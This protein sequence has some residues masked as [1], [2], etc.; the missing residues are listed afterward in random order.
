MLQRSLARRARRAASFLLFAGLA[1]VGAPFNIVVNFIGGLSPTQQAVFTTAANTWTALLPEYQPGINIPSLTISAQGTAIDGVGNVLGSAGPDLLNVTNQGGFWLATTG[2]MQFDTADLAN[3]EANNT[4][5]PVV[6]HE[7]AHVMGFG[8]LWRLNN[9]YAPVLNPGQFTGANAI[10]AYQT[11]FNQP[12]SLFVPVELG[13]GPGTADGHWDEVDFGAGPT[14]IISAQGD[15]QFEL[16]T[17]WL[18]TPYFISNTTIASFVDIGFQSAPVAVPEPG[19]IALFGA[20]LL[21]VA[22]SRRRS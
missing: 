5:L 12:G 21:F 6:L 2:S 4:L 13:G 3:L 10:A 9:V 22:L 17:G 19:T 16:M 18:N 8:T 20:G 11:E 15:K 7:M 14:G 1:A